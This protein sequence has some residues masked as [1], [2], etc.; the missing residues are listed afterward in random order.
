MINKL[1]VL[2]GTESHNFEVGKRYIYSE[3]YSIV[4][5][6]FISN[7]GYNVEFEDGS[8]MDVVTDNVMVYRKG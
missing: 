8:F 2:N 4:T 7:I 1:F 6:I 5:G 3:V